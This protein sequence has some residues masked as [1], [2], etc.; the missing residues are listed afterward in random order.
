MR[1]KIK[2]YETPTIEYVGGNEGIS[3]YGIVIVDD[4]IVILSKI[5]YNTYRMLTPAIFP[6]LP[7]FPYSK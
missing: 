7:V 5:N 4:V 2:F 6:V 1:K 3:L